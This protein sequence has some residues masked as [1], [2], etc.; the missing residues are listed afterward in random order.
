MALASKYYDRHIMLI[1]FYRK[2][3]LRPLIGR[4]IFREQKKQ[5]AHSICE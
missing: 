2:Q 3:N 1:I 4:Q 5:K